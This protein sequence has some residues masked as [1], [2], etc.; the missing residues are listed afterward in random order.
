LDVGRSAEKS[1]EKMQ[2]II[3]SLYPPLDQ[4]EPLPTLYTSVCFFISLLPFLIS[5]KRLAVSISFP[6][7][8]ALC[9]YQPH[10]TFGIP[11]NDYYNSAPFIALPLCYVDFVL[12]TPREGEDAPVFLWRQPEVKEEP[13]PW[14][15]TDLMSVTDR[16]HWSVRL[17]FAPHRGIGWNWQAKGVPANPHARLP[18]W[19]FVG[20][21]TGWTIFYYVQSVVVLVML[22]WSS[23]VLQIIEEERSLE[24]VDGLDWEIIIFNAM[25]GWFGAI[26]VWDRLCCVYSAAAALSVSLN[27]FDTWEWPP[28]MGSLDDAWSV[29]QVWR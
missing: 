11:S 3:A 14:A 10:Y 21:H 6:L 15:W 13:E 20:I 29:R 18:K 2:S 24:P 1:Q 7:L 8:L 9:I 22:G 23:E 12:C 19:K 5:N 26:W 17:M 25:V 16:F 4:R 28:L 27:M